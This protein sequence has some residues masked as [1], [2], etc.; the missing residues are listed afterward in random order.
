[1]PMHNPMLILLICIVAVLTVAVMV[2][3][4]CYI[5]SQRQMQQKNEAII[6]EMRQN[7]QLRE[8]LRK[9]LFINN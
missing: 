7:M 4:W 6:R 9:Q 1:M 8:E 5:S 2:L 3:L